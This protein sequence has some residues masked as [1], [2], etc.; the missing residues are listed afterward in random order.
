MI[1]KANK[2][3]D[4]LV[5]TTLD[6]KSDQLDRDSEKLIYLDTNVIIDIE[7][8][9]VTTSLLAKA[10]GLELPLFPFSAA[11]IQEA[12]E[13]TGETEE[14]RSERISRR[15]DS[16]E[17]ISNSLYLYHDPNDRSVQILQET[18][19]SVWKTINEVPFGRSAMKQ[20]VNLLPKSI[21]PGVRNLLE[22]SAGEL[23]NLSA[24]GAIRL[25]NEKLT[26]LG[27]GLSIT[28]LI[29]KS[30][31][32]NPQGQSFDLHNRMAAVFELL[33]MLGYWP[34]KNTDNSNY[35]RFWDANHAFFASC[36]DCFISNDKRMR[37]KTKA[38]YLIYGIGTKVVSPNGEEQ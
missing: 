5:A 19:H 15:L 16:I 1:T 11:H 27:I 12:K 2:K 14:E 3:W 35:A 26:T 21:R 32:Y 20:L 13:I 24:E 29:E 38:A 30:I 22:V 34:D 8:G 31:S 25:L 10:A 33:D 28:G 7:Q 36:C 18:P 4:E 17:T 9:A 6:A 23:N 37:N